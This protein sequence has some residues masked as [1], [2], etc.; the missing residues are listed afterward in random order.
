M[1]DQA[2]IVQ[3]I[4]DLLVANT[5]LGLEAVYYGD[6]SGIPLTPS[7]AVE[8]GTKE[9][10]Y[11]QTGLQT[12]V[13]VEVHVI[14]YHGQVTDAQIIKKALDEYAQTVEDVLHLDNTLGGLVISGLVA[15]VEPGVAVVARSQFYAHRLVW[16][17]MIK[18]RIGV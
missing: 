7:A 4:V 2:A 3:A 6:Q 18:E 5:Q 17:G 15:S 11:N 14:I 12:N 9:R 8:L 16:Q 1:S 13:V 10:A